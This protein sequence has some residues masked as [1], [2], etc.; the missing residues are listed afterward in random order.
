MQE[1]QEQ[2]EVDDID[3][4][5][6]SEVQ[7]Y[8]TLPQF[9][10]LSF[11]S[12]GLYLLWWIYSSWKYFKTRD[13]LDITP[14]ARAIFSV[15]F[16]YALYDRILMYA[17]EKGYQESYSPGVLFFV[18]FGSNLLSRLPDPYWLL[19]FLSILSYIAPVKALSF[20]QQ[21]STR[22]QWLPQQNFTTAQVVMLLLG[23]IFWVVILSTMFLAES[24]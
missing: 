2:W 24:Y 18:F 13:A 1:H 7:Y 15:F 17:K 11:F 9:L 21:Q 16:Q 23:I 5:Q 8:Q 20:A 3:S 19:S 14:V 22:E 4:D 12:F 10:L 6:I